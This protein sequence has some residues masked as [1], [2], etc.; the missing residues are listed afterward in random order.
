MK[1]YTVTIGDITHVVDLQP[2]NDAEHYRVWVDGQVYDVALS[3][4]PDHEPQVHPHPSTEAIPS[5]SP[6]AAR[7]RPADT[8]TEPADLR[9][10][11][12]GVILEVNVEPGAEVQRGD[13]VLVLEAM[14]MKNA[15][16]SPR[17]GIV[18]EVLVR[19]GQSVNYDEPLLRYRQG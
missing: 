7:D 2:L 12:P 19:P 5:A 11:M 8:A 13:Q 4:A 1:R 6:A 16:R 18:A 3:E 14:K 9:A 17:S 10:P 15:I